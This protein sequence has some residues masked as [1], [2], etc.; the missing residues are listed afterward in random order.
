MLEEVIPSDTQKLTFKYDALG[1]R[2]EKTF[3]GKSTQWVWDGNTPLHEWTQAQTKETYT[4]D[5]QGEIKATVPDDLTTWVFEE[6]SFVPM[7][8][9]KG[10]ETYSIITDYLGTPAEMYDDKGKRVWACELD[11]YGKVRTLEGKAEDCPFRYQG[12]YEDVE[13]GLYYNRFRYYSADEGGYIS[14]DPIGLEGNNPN[15]YAYVSDTNDYIDVFGLSPYSGKPPEPGR[16]TLENT[17]GRFQPGRGSGHY[18]PNSD[19]NN[20]KGWIDRRGNLWVPTGS[21]PTAH[22]G[23]HWDVQTRGGNGYTNVYPGG[24]ESGGKNPKPDLGGCP[25]K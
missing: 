22:G 23:P 24:H 18:R 9:I 20:T 1:R 13:T 21:G 3:E 25:V 4:I 11:I 15:L 17:G 5:N 10:A 7:A 12:Q 19:F 6:N 14:Q 16:P 8:K 2:I